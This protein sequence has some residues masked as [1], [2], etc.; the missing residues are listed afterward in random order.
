[1]LAFARLTFVTLCVSLF[2]MPAS[3]RKRPECRHHHARVRTCF[4]NV[5]WTE[6]AGQSVWIATTSVLSVWVNCRLILDCMCGVLTWYSFRRLLWL[7]AVMFAQLSCEPWFH[8]FCFRFQKKKFTPAAQ[9]LLP[10]RNVALGFLLAS[11]RQ[12]RDLYLS[13]N[14]MN[15]DKDPRVSSFFCAKELPETSRWKMAL[16][17]LVSSKSWTSN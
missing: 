9:K 14:W 15:I 3:A 5:P 10:L 2:W 16:L 17:E 13:I 7:S 6:P 1:M 12:D 4:G 11:Q 8:R